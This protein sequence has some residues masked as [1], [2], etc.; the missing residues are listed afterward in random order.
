MNLPVHSISQI[1]ILTPPVPGFKRRLAASELRRGLLQLGSARRITVGELPGP[2]AE[3]D[4]LRF[5]L[6]TGASS[7]EAYEIA[8]TQEGAATVTITGAG[9]QALLYGIF[10]WLERQGAYFSVDG[11]LYPIEPP[12]ALVLPDAGRPWRGSP[13]FATRGLLP[14]PDFLNCI[15][16]YNREDFRA[17]LEAMLR[18]RFNTLGIHVYGQKD[19]WAESFLSFEYGG[20]GYTA[21]TDTTATDRWGYLPQRTSRYG[22]SAAQYFDAD[23]FGSDATR[24]ARNPW[25]AAEL[26]QAL[27]R[28]AF[29]YAEQLGIRTGVGFEPYQLP[30]EIFRATPPEVRQELEFRFPVPGGE[31]HISKFTFVDPKSRT[32]RYI[33]ETRLAQLMEAYPSVSYVYLWEDEFV[34]WVSQSQNVETPMEPFKHA[35]DFLRRHAPDKRLVIAGWGGVAR[36]FE[37]FHRHLPGDIVFAALSD[38]LGW[39]PIHEVFGKLEDRERW[40]IPWIEDDPSMWFPQLQSHRFERD[41]KLAEGYGCQGVLGIHWRHRIIEPVAGYLAH[42][43][44]ADMTASDDY[45]AYARTQARGARAGSLAA[46]FDDIDTNR[47]FLCTWTGRFQPDGH[48]ERQEFAGDYSEA[49]LP[50]RNYVITDAF[51]SRQAQAIE[52]LRGLV[53]SATSLL[54]RER[55]SYWYGQSR[56]LDP[57]ARA[58]KVGQK[59]T[60]L[61]ADQYARKQRDEAEAA[62]SVIHAE[63]VPLWIELLGYVREAVLAFQH[64]IATR[65][66]QGMLAS[67]HNKFVR[68]AT[69]R[70]GES[71]LE[72]LDEL[73]P[74]AEAARSAALAPDAELQA[75]VFIP[76]RPTRLSPGESV[77]ITAVAPGVHEPCTVV[78]H[79]RPIGTAGWRSAG[80]QR[81]GRRTFALELTMPLDADAGLEYYVTG[82]FSSAPTPVMRRAPVEGAYLI[83]V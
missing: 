44:W 24:D 23:V 58:W 53:D 71:L 60:R 14:W 48:I 46:L 64:T 42:R 49:F 7:G 30:D 74:E 67:V 21:F 13:R 25:E 75:A 50:E 73:P 33:L 28:E 19:K 55:L 4:E 52:A 80:M 6:L 17:Y 3:A 51:V 57:Y 11:D 66:D 59:L 61:I 62:A 47:R 79:W 40:P 12:E 34:N 65:N 26:A 18:M 63:G 45:Q 2:T 20:I 82:A 15:T 83:S 1:T 36:N 77:L 43:T 76:T 5:V 41:L 35:H 31:D 9:E 56:F 29:A 78:L 8:V 38:M 27:W 81:V 37:R 10:D 32:A 22:M 54:E 72:F 16:V 39:D 69:F 68:I 70:M